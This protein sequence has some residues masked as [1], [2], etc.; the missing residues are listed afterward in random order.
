MRD[1][2]AHTPS[3]MSDKF[4]NSIP[5]VRVRRLQANKYSSRFVG[6]IE[7]AKRIQA[8]KQNAPAE[9]SVVGQG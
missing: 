3:S 2:V 5:C 4:G 7:E 6:I 9:E 8:E 1:L